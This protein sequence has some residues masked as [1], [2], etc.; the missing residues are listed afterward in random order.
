[1]KISACYIVKNEEKNLRRSLES[2]KDCIDELI[3]VDTGSTDGTM[4]IAKEFGARIYEIPWKDDFSWAK[5]VAKEKATG[6][7]VIFL[8]ADEFFSENT[9]KNIR[10]IVEQVNEEIDILLVNMD[11][12][13]T[14][15]KDEKILL[16]FA[17]PR[18]YRNLLEL[19]YAGKIH[20]HLSINGLPLKYNRVQ[21]I[22][23]EKLNLIHTGYA[24]SLSVQKAARNLR[25]LKQEL[26]TT[27]KPEELYAYIAECYVALGYIEKV[28]YYA[29]LDISFGRRPTNYAS[30]SWR[31]LLDLSNKE[32]DYSERK[33]IALS[34]VEIFPEIPEFH[35]E[36]AE[37]YA[38]EKNYELA[39]KEAGKAE[40]TF[41]SNSS[42]EPIK[43]T[44]VMLKQLQ[45]RKEK[46]GMIIEKGESYVNRLYG[47]YDMLSREIAQSIPM[48]MKILIKCYGKDDVDLSESCEKLERVL[49]D[50]LLYVIK[51]WQLN[52]KIDADY[53]DPYIS[54]LTYIINYGNE[55]QLEKYIDVIGDFD[56]NMIRQIADKLYLNKK[57]VWA[58]N[59]YSK[60][61][62]NA[63][64]VDE[65][66]WLYAGVCQYELSN[67]HVA[68]ECFEKALGFDEDDDVL[69]A[70]K[71]WNERQ[72][73]KN[74]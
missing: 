67:Y 45:E 41:I 8:D 18:I 16:S 13:D 49:S 50:D 5:N 46:W 61:P 31:I 62:Q 9:R 30:K 59:L 15:S 36:L 23:K 26:E 65:K 2:I 6:E 68:A 4:K 47:L 74:A 43:F 32:K 33:K 48:T 25:I 55:I 21:V 28:K 66:F 39:I 42:I 27:K 64:E 34:A 54:V 73:K 52:E 22:P 19:T 24:S 17:A 1:M 38:Y 3:V 12:I 58:W 51:K 7:W 70:Y 71:L 11:N 72:M 35:A 44:Q 53:F 63:P 37:C 20:E 60:L 56:S 69:A 40:E 57:Y 29:K 14:D 10:K